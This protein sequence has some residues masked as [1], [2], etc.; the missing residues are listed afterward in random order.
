MVTELTAALQAPLNS[1][2]GVETVGASFGI[3]ILNAGEDSCELIRKADFAMYQAKN[4][5]SA[6]RIDSSTDRIFA[7]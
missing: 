1:R 6:Y 7:G 2:W 4:R 3:A 5:D